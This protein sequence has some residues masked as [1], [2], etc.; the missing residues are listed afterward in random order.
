MTEST[1]STE[2]TTN[3]ARRACAI[4]LQG[5]ESRSFVGSAVL[6][7]AAFGLPLLLRLTLRGAW[8]VRAMLLSLRLDVHHAF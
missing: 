8:L 4:L 2:Q 5:V 1:R 7:R 3:R 6:A